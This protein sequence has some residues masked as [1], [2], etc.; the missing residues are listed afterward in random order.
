MTKI[1]SLFVCG[2][3]VITAFTL[4]SCNS[5]NEIPTVTENELPEVIAQDFNSRYGDNTIEPCQPLMICPMPCGG[6]FLRKSPML[7]NTSL[8]R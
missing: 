2:L 4:V 6:A 3:L 5:E 8:G 7:P 1:S